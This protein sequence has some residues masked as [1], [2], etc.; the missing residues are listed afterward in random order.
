MRITF[1]E[2]AHQRCQV[3]NA[4][5]RMRRCEKTGRTKMQG[6]DGVVA[7]MLIKAGPPVGA[8]AVARL[9]DRPET[10]TGS[11]AHKTKMTAMLTRH[12]LEN[13][14]ALPVTLDAKHDPLVSPLHGADSRRRLVLLHSFGNSSP[15]AR[16]RSGSSPQFSR[17]LTNKN[18]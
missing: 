11:A 1:R 14:V 15:M 16:Y 12:Q 10:R 4:V 6:L 8:Y 2:Q 9:E 3:A 7:E 5:D 17:T 13:G 18:K